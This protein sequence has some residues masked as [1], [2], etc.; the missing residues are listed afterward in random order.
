LKDEFLAADSEAQRQALAIS[1][2]ERVYD[3]AVLAPLGEY[4]QLTAI[5]KEAIGGIVTSPVGVFWGITKN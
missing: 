3:A 2:Q 5:R 1:I 4:K